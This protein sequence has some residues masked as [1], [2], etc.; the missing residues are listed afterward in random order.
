MQTSGPSSLQTLSRWLL[1]G[2]W[3][4][5]PVRTLTAVAAIAV[6]VALGF[7][8]H[9]INAAAFNEFSAAVQSLS[10]QADVQV[11]GTEPVFD[12]AIYGRLAARP[13]VAIASPVLEIAASLPG[14]TQPLKIVGLDV[15]RAGYITPDL[16]GAPAS[17]DA[18][19]TL[20]DDALFLSPA[21]QRW[22]GVQPGDRVTFQRGTGELTL[23]VAGSLQRARVGQQLGVMDI[24]A[25]QWRFDRVGKLSRVD[26]KL[27][28]GV[29]RN[30]FQA[31][32]AQELARDYPGRFQ[33]GRPNDANQESRNSNLSRAYRVNLSVLALVALFTG[34]FLV[35]STQALSVMRR[36][37]Q[38]ALLRVLG[39]E[40]HRL[41]RQVLIEG[42]CLGVV[43][44]GL[45]IAGGYG[46]AAV[47]LRFFGGDLGAGYFAGVQPQVQFTPV[48][49]F[50]YFALGVGVALL[51]CLTPA[52]EA[53]RATPAIALKSGADEVALRRLTRPWPAL[54]ALALA[55]L[56]SRLPPV[57]ELPVFGY[58]SIALLLIGGIALMPRIAA[59]AFRFAHARWTAATAHRSA[60]PAVPTLT[61][62]R[63]ANASGQAGIALGGVLSSFSLMVAMAIMVASFRVSVDNWI[64]QVLPADLY[65][66]TASAGG[67]SGLT[68]REQEAIRQAPGIA[69]AEFLRLRSVS[70][71]PDRPNVAL[72]ARDVDP[73]APGRSMVLVGDAVPQTAGNL[74]LAWVSEAMADLY[75]I[76]AGTTLD[77]PLAGASRPFFVAGIWRDYARVNGAVAIARGDYV[78]LTGDADVSDAALWVTKDASAARVQAALKALPFGAAIDVTAP[79]EI[80][81]LSLRIF[82]RSF[83]VT[84]LL[85]A[86]AIVIGLFGVAATFS[87]QTLARSKEFGMLRHIG[88]TRRQILGILALEGGALT[89]LGIATGFVLGWAI[90]L[91]LVH[92]VNPQSFH[93]TM[94]M[95]YPWPLLVTVAAALLAASMLTALLSGRQALSGGPIRAVREDW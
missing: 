52:W 8:I 45:G 47:A 6:G 54:A 55:L 40:R 67:T 84:Y 51:G 89:A 5:H 85:E 56:F 62:A 91:I 81:A 76:R 80:R 16:I 38:F 4:A 79:S 59:L 22:L 30:A 69:R 61:L 57:F 82:D 44:A 27:R 49:A 75:R 25:A 10:G 33:V 72:L 70:I 50:V 19:D 20:A 66:R 42:A 83:A 28:D 95:H 46:I 77:L 78:R 29:D 71:A 41:L 26:L 87:A 73:A 48:A 21:A 23:R 93:W 37:S 2:E 74:P 18:A 15:F 14:G 64:L 88:V 58:L 60:T 90:S 63:L 7:A 53:A 31:A 17:S 12:E 43:G 65:A 68:P 39:L 86:I 34:A 24:G 36:R 32:L 94:Q 9:L 1:L 11:S 92:V 3:R 35:F 13:G